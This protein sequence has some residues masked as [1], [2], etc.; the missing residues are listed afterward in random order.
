MPKWEYVRIIINF[1]K[2]A[3]RHTYFFIV[4]HIG[5]NHP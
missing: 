5:S 2:F 1:P 3:T 4:L